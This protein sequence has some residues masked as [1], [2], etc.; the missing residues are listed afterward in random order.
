MNS[1]DEAT[2]SEWMDLE[3]DGAL[4][5][6][7]RA[8]LRDLMASRPELAIER[9]ALES[10]HTLFDEGRIAVRPGF[11]PQ[12]M[13]ALPR[14]PA[15]RRSESAPSIPAWG[16]PLAA[17]LAF[18]LGAAWL[19]AGSGALAGGALGGTALAMLDLASTSV[20][21]GSGLLF[22]TW[23][24]VG[25]G[26]GELLGNSYLNLAVFALMVVCLD[27]LFFSMLRRPATAEAEDRAG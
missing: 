18:A 27:L 7:E 6:G 22:A 14:Q 26:L 21:A 4:G 1:M 24:G 17:M 23:R 25:L 3:V 8:R 9:R 10:L 12:V 16:W 20:L 2:L 19:L 15:W 5:D 11:Q 13:A